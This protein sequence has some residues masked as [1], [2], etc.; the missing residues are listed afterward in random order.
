LL[1]VGDSFNR[2]VEPEM[3]VGGDAPRLIVSVP[4]RRKFSIGISRSNQSNNERL[5][6]PESDDVPEL[7]LGDG[8][9]GS[10]CCDGPRTAN[11]S[12]DATNWRDYKM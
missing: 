7:E 10:C 5:P 8:V 1:F 11:E 2:V 4:K 3:L 6:E 12:D 9:P